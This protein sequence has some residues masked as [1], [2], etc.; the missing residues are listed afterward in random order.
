MDYLLN[1]DGFLK[2][3]P[4]TLVLN[5]I[6]NGLPSKLMGEFPLYSVI[7]LAVLNLIINGLPSK[8]IHR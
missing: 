1:F 3:N 6:I 5:L 2:K 7:K 8:Q 4:L